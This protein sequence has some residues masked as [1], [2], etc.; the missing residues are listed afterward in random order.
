MSRAG[1]VDA[2]LYV[3]LVDVCEHI[4]GAVMAELP[5]E[6]WESYEATRVLVELGKK[7]ENNRYNY[8][9]GIVVLGWFP[10]RV[11]R[12]GGEWI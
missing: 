8:L 2:P 11:E 9:C 7:L 3:K 12:K 6:E 4:Q 10:P 5:E 1:H